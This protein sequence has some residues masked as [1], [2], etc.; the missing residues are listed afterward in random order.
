VIGSAGG[1]HPG[2]VPTASQPRG[3]ILFDAV[4]LASTDRLRGEVGR[5]A[6]ALITDGVDQGSRV[7]L[8]E[9]I[10]AAHKSDAII[11]SIHAV[12]YGFYQQAGYYSAY[13]G[14]GDLKRMS[15]ETGGRLFRVDRKHT[16][17]DIFREI[18]EELRS[19]YAIGFSSSNPVRDGGFRRVDI[20]TKDKNLRVQARKG[21]YATP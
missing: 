13:P 8:Q 21:Y 12:D 1:L 14:D 4:Y 15:E 17:D 2:P 20:K 7:R 6:I 5:K 19:Q 18:Q 16:L 10:E 3:T 11:Y 9:A